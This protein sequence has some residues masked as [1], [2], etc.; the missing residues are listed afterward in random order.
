MTRPIETSP[1]PKNCAE[2][3][4][5][6]LL[7]I[8]PDVVPAF[9]QIAAPLIGRA[10]EHAD[11]R[12]EIADVLAAV[13]ARDMQL[14]IAVDARSMAV[15]AACV[16]EI[17]AYPRE[18]RCGLVFCAG[19]EADRWIRHLPEIADWAREQGCAALELQGRPGWER[20][21]RDWQKTHVLLRKRL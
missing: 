8:P 19:R 13:L 7:G 2:S 20:L 15:E 21:L 17:V 9:W 14:W 1:P 10:I 16:T 5:T 18:K 11:G 6:M 12:Y 4:P 3:P